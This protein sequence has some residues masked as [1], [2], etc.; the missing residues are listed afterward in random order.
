MCYRCVIGVSSLCDISDFAFYH[1]C[2]T[3]RPCPSPSCGQSHSKIYQVHHYFQC[4]LSWRNGTLLCSVLK[5]IE[6]ALQTVVL[7][8]RGADTK[9]NANL[10][11]KDQEIG[12]KNDNLEIAM[13]SISVLPQPAVVL[14]RRSL[15][16]EQLL[17]PLIHSYR[18][19]CAMCREERESLACAR[20]RAERENLE[21]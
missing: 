6:R 4:R 20:C 5:S 2:T 19:V 17:H 16:G 12:T 1:E 15:P 8:L 7:A 10:S 3:C 18:I 9:T 21:M 13:S 14:P 11:E